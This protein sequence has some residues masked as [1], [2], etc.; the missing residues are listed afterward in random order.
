MDSVAFIWGQFH[1]KILI[2]VRDEFENYIFKFTT[3]L[4]KLI[5][6]GGVEDKMTFSDISSSSYTKNKKKQKTIILLTFLTGGN[7]PD[8]KY[9][10]HEMD[11]SEADVNQRQ[12]NVEPTKNVA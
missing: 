12:P 1:Q 5:A 2:N 4:P 8:I 3:T 10:E 6:V 7:I 9:C 11:W